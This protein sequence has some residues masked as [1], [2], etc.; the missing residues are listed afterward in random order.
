MEVTNDLNVLAGPAIAVLL[1]TLKYAITMY[2]DVEIV[3][4]LTL[5]I[6]IFGYNHVTTMMPA[7]T[8]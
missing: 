8:R 5:E 7:T 3:L 1:I 4:A 6:A 2:V